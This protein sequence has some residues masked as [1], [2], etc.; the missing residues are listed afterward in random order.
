M[1]HKC[2]KNVN[3][4]I[5]DYNCLNKAVIDTKIISLNFDNKNNCSIDYNITE[6]HKDIICLADLHKHQKDS[7]T[8]L[9]IS[10]LNENKID[11]YLKTVRLYSI[12]NSKKKVKDYSKNKNELNSYFEVGK[13]L[14]EAQGGE[15]RAKYGN[16]LIKNWSKELT[17][18]YG[19]G[20][21]YTNL[22]RMRKLYL[23]FKNIGPV[24][25]LS[26]SHYRYILPIVFQ[27][28]HRLS[29]AFYELHSLN[30]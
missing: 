17:D 4:N 16:G 11:D 25:Q 7:L 28:L 6:E 8:E 12:A 22:S 1:Q 20:Y 26:W 14:V 24:G 15:A 13:V 23:I 19:K 3:N 2:N 29:V 9:S 5:E 10:T 21:D 27:M 18:L 30:S